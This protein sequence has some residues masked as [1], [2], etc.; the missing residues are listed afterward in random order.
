MLNNIE[1]STSQ[2]FP[3]T[4]SQ[5][6]DISAIAGLDNAMLYVHDDGD[7][8]VS[9][10]I[11]EQGIWEAYET[12]LVIEY[13]KPRDIF[14]DVGANIGYYSV[15]AG[16]C[17]GE[18]G[19]VFSF[20]P[21]QKNFQQLQHNIA[22]N[23]LACVTPFNVAL[24]SE[25][26]EGNIYLNET[27]WGDHQIYDDASGR[28]NQRI[29]LE[30]GY[31]LLKDQCDQ[32]DFIKIDTQGAEYGVITGL[33]PLIQNNLS[34]LK[35]IIEFWPKGLNRSEPSSKSRPEHNTENTSCAHRLLDLLVSFNLSMF[36][37]D[38]INHGLI[39]CTEKDL[40]DWIC[41]VE[42][43]PDNEGF[44]NLLLKP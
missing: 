42:A 21:E 25:K 3:L 9:K 37:I 15:V 14:L 11:K 18:Q 28:H 38:H 34:H 33:L 24:A 16:F 4:L 5:Q 35:M 7:Q 2:S 30:N 22:L 39:P 8:H 40:R 17:V 6:C 26:G 12:Q 27:N 32:V 36:I 10:G 13:L 31:A 41:D 19:R 23:Q 1:F 29:Q 43:N 20:E 44:I